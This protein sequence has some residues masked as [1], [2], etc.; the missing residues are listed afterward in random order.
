MVLI[1]LGT[2]IPWQIAMGEFE[3]ENLKTILSIV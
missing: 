1:R 2:M 3:I